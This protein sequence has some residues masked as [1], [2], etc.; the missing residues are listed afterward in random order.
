[1]S[2]VEILKEHLQK[3][4]VTITGELANFSPSGKETSVKVWGAKERLKGAI[5]AAQDVIRND[6][7]AAHIENARIALDDAS[8]QLAKAVLKE[9][10]A[11]W[12]DAAVKNTQRNMLQK[13]RESDV[14]AAKKLRDKLDIENKELETLIKLAALRNLPA[15]TEVE[16]SPMNIKD[17]KKGGMSKCNLR[18]R[19]T[20]VRNTRRC[21]KS[22]APASH[23]RTSRKKRRRSTKKR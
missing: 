5:E 21:R 7:I 22:R 3:K 13:Q 16:M 19:K 23:K 8:S 12:L 11:G 17:I 6:N 20:R 14:M 4:I 15:G 1:M 2:S 9:K 18:K 10:V